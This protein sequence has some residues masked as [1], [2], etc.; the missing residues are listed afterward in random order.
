[1]P[2]CIA[3]GNDPQEFEDWLDDQN[4]MP[5]EKAYHKLRIIVSVLNEGW[6]P[7]FTEDEVRWM[8]WFTLWTAD[9]LEN[10]SEQWKE[11]RSLMNLADYVGDYCGFASAHSLLA[12]SYTAAHFGSRLC[13]R[14]EALADYCG[15]Q[16]N[17][18]WADYFLIRK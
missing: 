5:D 3:S 16:F 2:H 4:F 8:P 14:S 17:Y 10:K 11:Q 15:K 7:K 18:L 9:E 12:P 13:L 6:V 1:L